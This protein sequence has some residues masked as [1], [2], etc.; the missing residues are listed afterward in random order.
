MGKKGNIMRKQETDE[1]LKNEMR[2][3]IDEGWAS[4]QTGRLH[5]GDDVFADLEA[6]LDAQAH[7]PRPNKDITQQP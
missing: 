5:D 3:K 1:G 2:R 6:Q 4:A 7:T